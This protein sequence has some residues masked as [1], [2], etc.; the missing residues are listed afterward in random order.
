VNNEDTTNV[1]A[2]GI[3]LHYTYFFGCSGCIDDVLDGNPDLISSIRD[4]AE[5]T[6]ADYYYRGYVDMSRLMGCPALFSLFMG[7]NDG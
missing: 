6:P 2:D 5:I 4:E 1:L 3:N 7:K